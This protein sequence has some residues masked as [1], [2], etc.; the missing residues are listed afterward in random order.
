MWLY[1]NIKYEIVNRINR[2]F[3]INIKIHIQFHFL[4]KS[5]PSHQNILKTN[6]R[7]LIKFCEDF[8]QCIDTYILYTVTLI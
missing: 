5:S 6:K 1:K 8:F 4:Q 2:Y 3:L 7:K